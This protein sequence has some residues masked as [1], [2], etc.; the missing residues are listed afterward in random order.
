M[1]SL[2][3]QRVH[4]SG[5]HCVLLIWLIISGYASTLAATGCC[6]VCAFFDGMVEHDNSMNDLLNSD[7]V[8]YCGYDYQLIFLGLAS[9]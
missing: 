2:S 5:C 1:S 4:N 9:A 6:D 8:M 7:Y 3:K